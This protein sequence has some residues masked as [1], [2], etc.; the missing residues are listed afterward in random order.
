MR[1][2]LA[3]NRYDVKHNFIY[4]YLPIETH[5]LRRQCDQKKKILLQDIHWKL[6]CSGYRS[7]I[8]GWKVQFFL[9]SSSSSFFRRSAR[10]FLAILTDCVGSTKRLGQSVGVILGVKVHSSSSDSINSSSR[11]FRSNCMRLCH[12]SW[13]SKNGIARRCVRWYIGG[14]G[15]IS[16]LNVHSKNILWCAFI[17]HQFHV[18]QLN[19][20]LFHSIELPN[21]MSN[22]NFLGKF[23]TDRLR[24][25]VLKLCSSFFENVLNS[26]LY[27]HILWTRYG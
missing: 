25:T 19:I 10:S 27:V 16:G 14:N 3:R 1:V 15:W 18:V 23:R 13:R 22:L 24:K 5:G 7:R 2:T 26:L 20:F 11:T 6:A 12:F 4:I 8:W 17:F 9:N 21:K